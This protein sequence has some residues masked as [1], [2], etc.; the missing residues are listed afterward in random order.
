MTEKR[1]F[2]VDPGPRVPT[3]S[4]PELSGKWIE[5]DGVLMCDGYL[6]RIE[7]EDHCESK[8][9]ADWTPFEFDGRTYYMIPLTD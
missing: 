6:T 5:K 3:K 2:V 7:S 4:R 1:G 8:I 9:P